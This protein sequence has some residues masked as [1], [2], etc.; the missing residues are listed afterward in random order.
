MWYGLYLDVY[1]KPHALRW[2]FSELAGAET[3]LLELRMFEDYIGL[4]WFCVQIIREP[5]LGVGY[6]NLQACSLDGK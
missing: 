4:A 2:G 6:T 1:P 5:T 3:V